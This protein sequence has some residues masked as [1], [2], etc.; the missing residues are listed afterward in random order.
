MQLPARC[1]ALVPD[2]D[3]KRD[4]ASV[5][6][7]LAGEPDVAARR[8]VAEVEAMAARSREPPHARDDAAAG[9]RRDAGSSAVAR[10]TLTSEMT[11]PQVAAALAAAQRS[12]LPVSTALVAYARGIFRAINLGGVQAVFEYDGGDADKEPSLR[13]VAASA[14]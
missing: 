5:W 14:E 3:F 12:A 6:A 7:S 1:S 8:L 9:A 4:L 10:V 13:F 2:S 11:E